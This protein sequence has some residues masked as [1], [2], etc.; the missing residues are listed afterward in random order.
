MRAAKAEQR[1]QKQPD[2]RDPARQPGA[3]KAE[4]GP[5]AK[6]R[7]KARAANRAPGFALKLTLAMLLVLTLAL[8]LGGTV[9]LAGNFSDSLNE[10]GRQAEAQHLLQC[11]ALESNLLDVAARGE[12]VSDS[13]LARYGSMLADYTGGR[14]AMAAIFCARADMAGADAGGAQDGSSTPAESA[15]YAPAESAAGGIGTQNGSNAPAESA[16]SAPGEAPALR[17]VYSSFPWAAQFFLY[18]KK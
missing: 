8:S 16:A 4:K 10:A 14:M 6:T 17:Q 13:H 12:T 11:Y 9:L 18:S 2:A 7:A 15:S 1:P 5:H 3:Q